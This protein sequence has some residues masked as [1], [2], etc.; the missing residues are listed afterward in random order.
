MPFKGKDG[1]IKGL[2]GLVFKELN[3][4]SFLLQLTLCF[5]MVLRLLAI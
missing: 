4:V 2:L 5:D 3:R 1:I